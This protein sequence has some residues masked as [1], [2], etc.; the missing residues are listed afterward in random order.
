ME[1]ADITFSQTGRTCKALLG[2]PEFH[3][4]GTAFASQENVTNGEV[5]GCGIRQP[6]KRTLIMP[7]GT[8]SQIGNVFTI[9]FQD[10]MA[11]APDPSFVGTPVATDVCIIKGLATFGGFF[12]DD[13]GLPLV[14]LASSSNGGDFAEQKAAAK[15]AAA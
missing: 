1:G 3:P 8:Q 10:K 6:L 2:K 14:Q 4:S 15:Y 12:C 11:V 7:P 5:I 9:E 13:A